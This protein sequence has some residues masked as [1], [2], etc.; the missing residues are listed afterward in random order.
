MDT[1]LTAVTLVSLAIAAALAVVVTRLLRAERRRSDARV[2]ALSALAEAPAR[3]RADASARQA[4]IRADASTGQA[5]TPSRG[6]TLRA[7][8]ADLEIRRPAAVEVAGHSGLFAEP[9]VSSPWGRRLAV[10]GVI[11]FL[12]GTALF[13]LLQQRDAS[14]GVGTRL[15]AAVHQNAAGVSSSPLELVSLRHTQQGETL[16]I[17]GLVQNPRSG[18]PLTRLVA[19]AVVFGPDGTFLAGGKAPLDFTTLSAGDESPFVI[20]V[21]VNGAVARYRVGFR[22]EDGT[23]VAHIDRRVTPAGT[24]GQAATVSRD[25]G[26]GVSQ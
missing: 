24:K 10:I 16:T 19:T 9:E 14:P 23:V 5:K 3:L 17:V 7:D 26:P 11:L 22:A 25:H 15:S 8:A 1:V 12:S 4:H 13:A 21:P 20:N 2:A 18:A 6:V